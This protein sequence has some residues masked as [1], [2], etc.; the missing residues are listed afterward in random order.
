[1]PTMTG[2]NKREQCLKQFRQQIH[3]KLF[4]WQKN[5]FVKEYSISF[6]WWR[7]PTL[8]AVETSIGKNS[9]IPSLQND[10]TCNVRICRHSHY[11]EH[12][13][14]HYYNFLP[15]SYRLETYTPKE[16]WRYQ[17]PVKYVR[18][19]SKSHYMLYLYRRANFIFWR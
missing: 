18:S 19:S 9:F 5:T 6:F 12:C 15:D 8:N 14:L 10:G 1:M 11:L 16:T 17:L 4:K 3:T 7:K 2:M 13:N